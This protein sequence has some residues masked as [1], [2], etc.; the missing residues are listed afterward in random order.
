MLWSCGPF[1][2]VTSIEIFNPVPVQMQE[3]YRNLTFPCAVPVE[4]CNPGE[5]LPFFVLHLYKRWN[6]GGNLPFL[7][8][9]K[10]LSLLLRL[11]VGS[12]PKASQV[13]RKEFIVFTRIWIILSLTH[14]SQW[15]SH[16]HSSPLSPK[17]GPTQHMSH[18]LF[19]FFRDSIA[20]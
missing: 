8:P 16:M 18:H 13:S 19:V 9:Q 15:G 5:F 7:S 1:S 12:L 6:P 11:P 20:F 17:T 4:R 3:S 14:L 2:V 10:L